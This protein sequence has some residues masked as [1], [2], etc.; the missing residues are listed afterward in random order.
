MYGHPRDNWNGRCQVHAVETYEYQM[1]R[2][3][4]LDFKFLIEMTQGSCW[5][6]PVDGDKPCSILTLTH[7]RRSIQPNIGATPADDPNGQLVNTHYR[8]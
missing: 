5:S 2:V 7:T 6:F 4:E 3:T 1:F 8:V